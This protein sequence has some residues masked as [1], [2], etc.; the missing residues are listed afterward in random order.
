M[1]G[2]PGSTGLRD[3]GQTFKR[4]NCFLY[5]VQER[6][7]W[8]DRKPTFIGVTV[9]VL[10]ECKVYKVHTKSAKYTKYKI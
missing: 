1:C 3:V 7:M 5:M 2:G 9:D 10:R 8:S 6:Q 4:F